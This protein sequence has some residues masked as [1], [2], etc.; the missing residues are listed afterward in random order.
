MTIEQ[1]TAIVEIADTA[2]FSKAARKLNM[3]QPNLSYIIKNIEEQMGSPIFMRTKDGVFLTD[4]GNELVK[5]L[6]FLK[7][8]YALIN[9]ILSGRSVNRKRLSLN[10]STLNLYSVRS[11]FAEMINKYSNV[12]INFTFTDYST[13]S[14]VIN[15]INDVE[16]SVMGMINSYVSHVRR[17]LSNDAIE[18]HPIAE[19][20]CCA[21]IGRKSKYYNS[22]RKSITIAELSENTLLQYREN[23][24]NP[25]QSVI[26]ALGLSNTSFGKILVN[27]ADAFYSLLRETPAI[28]VDFISKNKFL[29]KLEI[30]DL[31]VLEIEDCPYTWE[32]SWIKKRQLPLSDI[33]AE[34]LERMQELF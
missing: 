19:L 18:Y 15:H 10:I 5:Q 7:N 12:P 14:D 11:V 4:K 13:F 1:L 31:K 30:D 24:D 27:S 8:D 17:I 9:E 33:A 34:F 6:K 20:S 28:G 23:P 3:S 25:E 32:V 26:H 2:S 16:L 21:I 22:D 29:Q